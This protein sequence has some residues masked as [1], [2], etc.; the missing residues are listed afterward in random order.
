MSN[1]QKL[2]PSPQGVSL[3][4][5]DTYERENLV[6]EKMERGDY[7]VSI[8][9]KGNVRVGQM[10]SVGYWTKKRKSTRSRVFLDVFVDKYV[11]V[12]GEEISQTEKILFFSPSKEDVATVLKAC[13]LEVAKER[14]YKVVKEQGYVAYWSFNYVWGLRA[15]TETVPA[16]DSH[17][18]IFWE[19][20]GLVGKKGTIPHFTWGGYPQIPLEEALC[21]LATFD[22]EVIVGD[23]AY[24][25]MLFTTGTKEC[26]VRKKFV[27]TVFDFLPP[28]D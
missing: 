14:L 16:E 23:D 5:Y 1:L 8:N 6:R 19:R 2:S 20:M 9:L 28:G 11:L 15:T 13:D 3:W 17:W 27:G 24:G 26:G 21:K 12:N 22:S 10:S 4:G 7:F 25:A 18:K